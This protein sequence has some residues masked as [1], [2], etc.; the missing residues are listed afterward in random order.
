MANQETWE[1]QI[2]NSLKRI[3]KTTIAGSLGGSEDINDRTT[4]ELYE[5]TPNRDLDQKQRHYLAGPEWSIIQQ[6]SLLKAGHDIFG[7]RLGF[8]IDFEEWFEDFEYEFQKN[9][10]STKKPATSKL[11]PWG[12]EVANR[13]KKL[14]LLT[15]EQARKQGYMVIRFWKDRTVENDSKVLAG[16]YIELRQQLLGIMQTQNVEVEVYGIPVTTYQERFRFL[17]QILLY[18]LEDSEDLD[19]NFGAVDGTISFR[20]MGETYKTITPQK[21]TVYA[22]KIAAE[23]GSNNGYIW[24]KGKVSCSYY[25][26]ETGHQLRINSRNKE[27]GKTLISKILSLQNLTPDWSKL[28]PIENED[29]AKAYPVIPPKEKIYGSEVYLPRKYP[30]ADVRFQRAELHIW[31]RNKPVILVDRSYKSKNALI[32]LP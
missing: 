15:K 1:R 23:F 2:L 12:K 24:K 3:R 5:F 10:P 25:S 14:N 7:D 20:I 9:L 30:I 22:N 13:P 18:F 28:K 4:W 27:V 32:V 6:S 31:G 8:T 19:P 26:P 16:T 21:A 29:P 11:K 17:P